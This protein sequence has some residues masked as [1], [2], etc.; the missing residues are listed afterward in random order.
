M[1]QVVNPPGYVQLLGF[2]INADELW[3]EPEDNRRASYSRLLTNTAIDLKSAGDTLIYTGPSLVQTI[4]HAVGFGFTAS[5]NVGSQEAEVSVGTD[6]PEFVNVIPRTT[7]A[8]FWP[9]VAVAV[10]LRPEN[11]VAF[12]VVASEQELHLH[13]ETPLDSTTGDAVARLYGMMIQEQ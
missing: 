2:P 9:A 4:I 10:I 12:N 5:G 6:S 11:G 13:V 7:L 8:G 1:T 3:I